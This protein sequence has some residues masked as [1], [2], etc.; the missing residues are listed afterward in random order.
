MRD[1]S[2]E[3]IQLEVDSDNDSIVIEKDDEENSPD[4]VCSFLDN[5]NGDNLFDECSFS[6]DNDPGDISYDKVNTDIHSQLP[7]KYVISAT[8]MVR[9]LT[10][11]L[12]EL[13]RNPRNIPLSSPDG[14]NKV[15]NGKALW[16]P[17]SD[18]SYKPIDSNNWIQDGKDLSSICNPLT[19][20]LEVG[21]TFT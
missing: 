21:I 18:V 17:P 14:V 3:S 6:D 7:L 10:D 2:N 8:D 4:S 20:T 5:G 13:V 11:P 16:F 1:D 9:S 15:K 12:Y 19:K